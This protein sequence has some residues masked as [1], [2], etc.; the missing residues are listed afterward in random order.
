MY[1][2]FF[3]HLSVLTLLFIVQTSFINVLVYPFN[4][5]NLLVIATLFFVIIS[6]RIKGLSWTLIAGIFL[7]FYSVFPLG[8]MMIGLV[9][10]AL[11]V[12]F[13]TRTVLIDQNYI[14]IFL[15]M[16]AGN[17]FFF[18]VLKLLNYSLFFTRIQE[19]FYK[20]HDLSGTFV[21][22]VI[23]AIIATG[24]LFISRLWQNY[25]KTYFIY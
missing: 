14:G 21:F 2:Q 19:S 16:L 13:I 11:L 10:A 7:E 1:L 25:I 17:T 24:F 15:V 23:G 8:I 6:G 5:I 3:R 22:I 9:A 18:L 4:Q 20:S 12:D